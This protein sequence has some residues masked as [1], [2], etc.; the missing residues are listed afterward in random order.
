MDNTSIND[1]LSH[2]VDVGILSSEELLVRKI[3][4]FYSNF[5]N[6]NTFIHIVEKG[7]IISLRLL[8]WFSTNYSK[9][10][11]IYINKIDIHADYKNQLDGYRKRFFDPFCRRQRILVFCRN[12]NLRNQKGVLNLDYK[13]LDDADTTKNV[14]GIVT[15]IGQLNFF[16]WCIERNIIAY[17]I[18]HLTSIEKQMNSKE[19]SKKQPDPFF[20]KTVMPVSIS[21]T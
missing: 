5:N 8:D 15:T 6:L 3:L 14:D 9:Y 7:N 13:H 18:T 10:N 12:N 1:S 21:F 4:K 19:K 17:I 16:K 20:H 11:K 2:E